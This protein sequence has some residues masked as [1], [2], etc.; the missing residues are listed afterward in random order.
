MKFKILVAEN[1]ARD[2][3]NLALDLLGGALNFFFVHDMISSSFGY[4]KSDNGDQPMFAASESTQ[5]VA[6]MAWP[7]FAEE[8]CPHHF[9]PE[10]SP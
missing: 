3:F 4:I 8:A 7:P 1:P 6:P 9:P 10:P 5:S 2:F